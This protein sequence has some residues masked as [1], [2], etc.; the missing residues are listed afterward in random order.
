MG[1]NARHFEP[2][3]LGDVRIRRLDGARTWRYLD[4]G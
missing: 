1:L 3:A 4:R 2:E